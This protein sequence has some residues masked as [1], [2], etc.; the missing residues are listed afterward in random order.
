MTKH[1]LLKLLYIFL[2]LGLLDA[3]YLTYEHYFGNVSFCPFH[4]PLID[5]GR[6]L[7]STYSM[8]GPVPLALLGA[9]HYAFFIG[10]NTWFLLTGNLW[11][12][13]FLLLQAL[14]GVAASGYL[15]YLQAGPIGSFCFFCLV[16]AAV[17]LLAFLT[18]FLYSRHPEQI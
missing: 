12:K 13:R 17:S 11:A 14:A 18:V 15:F 8:I 5:C 1:P 2:F 9:L 7:R 6:V 10:W 16:S 4:S 3:L